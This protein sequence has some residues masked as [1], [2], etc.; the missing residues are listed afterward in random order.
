MRAMGMAAVGG[1]ML[2]T[3]LA[4]A[5]ETPFQHTA[6]R[7]P[8]AARVEPQS[9]EAARPPLSQADRLRA[10]IGRPPAD[11]PPAKETGV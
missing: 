3:G 5:A 2:G 11:C 9:P 1:W 8:E 6:P 4:G 10:V 7:E